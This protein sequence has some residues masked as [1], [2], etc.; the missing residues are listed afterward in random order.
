MLETNYSEVNN[1]ISRMKTDGKDLEEILEYL[2]E[3][4]NNSANDKNQSLWFSLWMKRCAIARIEE[5]NP[6][7]AL[8][9]LEYLDINKL[10]I[11][12]LHSV[13]SIY[14]GIYRDL[15]DEDMAKKY[16]ELI[17]KIESTGK[18]LGNIERGCQDV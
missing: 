10:S 2:D 11:E 14:S 13:Y 15:G 17:I 12:Q 4:I 16:E 3:T 5:G 6:Q 1:N 9:Y 18:I 7:K 8:K